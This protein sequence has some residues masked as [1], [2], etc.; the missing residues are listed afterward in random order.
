MHKKLMH[1]AANIALF[2][3]SG[4]GAQ[5]LTDSA[6]AQDESSS[7]AAGTRYTGDTVRLD[8]SHPNS[9]DAFAPELP[10]TRARMPDIPGTGVYVEEV[11]PNLFYVTGGVY[12]S[13]FVVTDEGLV[14]IDAPPSFGN[15]LPDVLAEAA[16]GLPIAYLVYSHGHTDHIGGSSVFADVP[17]LQILAPASVAES[18]AQRGHPGILV[19]NLTYEDDYEFSLGGE[20]FELRTANYHS[21]DHDAII[22]L[23]NKKFLVAVDTVTPGE[24]PFMNFG[25]TSD[26]QAYLENFDELLAY[27]FDLLL[28]GHISFLATRDDVLEAQ[29]YTRDVQQQVRS[30]MPGFD[31]RVG[32]NLAAIGFANANLAYRMAIEG[33]RDECSAA[34]IDEW[35]DRLSVVDVYADSHCRMVILHAVMN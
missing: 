23:P 2:A 18:I 7:D 21:T 35:Q 13:A 3:V 34:L 6:I 22:Y 17:N 12:T 24:V 9:Y 33:I 4:I 28:S 26:F 32:E 30:R 20:V 16:P 5:L 10:A 11:K 25:A 8:P 27:D 19:P 31:Q 1:T 29:A 14:V 15:A